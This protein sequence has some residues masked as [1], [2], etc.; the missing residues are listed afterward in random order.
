MRVTDES[1]ARVP[2]IESD[3]LD[4][5]HWD[6]LQQKH[7]ELLEYI[8]DDEFGTEAIAYYDFNMRELTKY[9]GPPGAGQVPST[10][11][12]V[13]HIVMH[14]H[15]DGRTFTQ[16]DVRR[17]LSNDNMLTLSAVGNDGSLYLLEKM[18]NFNLD[19]ADYMFAKESLNDEYY[20][21]PEK[22][23]ELMETFLGQLS[24][25]GIRYKNWRRRI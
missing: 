4:E 16:R 22:Y 11:F 1:I 21:S 9:K 2:R 23:V 3:V 14:T 6:T 12:N 19:A 8:R 7:R 20:E 13:P 17:F 18:P 24:S 5:R 15:P 10:R 25:A